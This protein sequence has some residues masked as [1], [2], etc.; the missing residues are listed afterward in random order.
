MP[1]ILSAVDL[2]IPRIYGGNGKHR[3]AQLDVKHRHVKIRGY[4]R[5]EQH[6]N[7]KDYEPRS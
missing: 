3:Y 5:H 6:H 4:R 1:F 7:R 2:T